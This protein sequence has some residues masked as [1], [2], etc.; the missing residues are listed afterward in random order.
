[1]IESFVS[2]WVPNLL[3]V[4][5]IVVLIFT[6]RAALKQAG[7][8]EELTKSTEKQITAS[9]ASALAATEQVE[10]ARRQIAESLRPILTFSNGQLA[11]HGKFKNEGGGAALNIWW[12]YG[13]CG[14]KISERLE[15]GQRFAPPSGELKINFDKRKMEAQGMLLVYRSLAGITSATQITGSWLDP[16]SDYL[17]DVTAWERKITAPFAADPKE[18]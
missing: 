3:S 2:L 13:R 7:A 16:Q 4:A 6:C 17:P 10:V 14:G 9:E 1:V 11:G 8:A 18:T 15:L 12:T 5:T